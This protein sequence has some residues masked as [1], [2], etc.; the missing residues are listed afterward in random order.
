MNFFPKAPLV[1][2]H[3]VINL[4]LIMM[5]NNGFLIEKIIMKINVWLFIDK[6]RICY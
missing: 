4:F 6:K 2:M 3:I 5:I 1:Q